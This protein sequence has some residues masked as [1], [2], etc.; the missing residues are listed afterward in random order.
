MKAKKTE[1]KY[2]FLIMFQSISI[3]KK[4]FIMKK[5]IYFFTFFLVLTSCQ[6]QEADLIVINANAYTVDDAFSKAEAFAIKDGKFI[7]HLLNL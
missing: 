2:Y 5:I 3:M 7:G 1:M 4:L 6:Q